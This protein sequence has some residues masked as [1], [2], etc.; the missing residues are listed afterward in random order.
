MEIDKKLR[1]LVKDLDICQFQ[2]AKKIGVCPSAFSRWIRGSRI[3]N[4]ANLLVLSKLYPNI[5]THDEVIEWL[6]KKS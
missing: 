2:I 1:E 3:P 6:S 4:S 5:F